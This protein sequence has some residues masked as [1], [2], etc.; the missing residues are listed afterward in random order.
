MKLAF[1]ESLEASAVQLERTAA[2]ADEMGATVIAARARNLGAYF[3]GYAH[4]SRILYGELR[5][6][7]LTL[8][9][10]SAGRAHDQSAS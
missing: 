8:I 10:S 7:Q 4:Q 9:D 1:I 5:G 2:L 3:D 6:P